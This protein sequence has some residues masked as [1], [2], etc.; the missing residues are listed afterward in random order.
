MSNLD[1]TEI[2]A[3]L[4]EIVAAAK[5]DNELKALLAE[6]VKLVAEENISRRTKT[7]VEAKINPISIAATEGIERLV[8][9]LEKLDV[10]ALIAVIK[11]YGLDK[12]RK[13]YTWKTKDKL[14]NL[15]KER[16]SASSTRGDVFSGNDN[17]T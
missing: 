1:V 10:P 5:K 11:K 12:T 9:E 15:I 4:K 7:K 13:S 17:T 3:V 16:V 6:L 14:V 8:E 2:K